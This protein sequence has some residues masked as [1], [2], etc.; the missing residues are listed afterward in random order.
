MLSSAKN[1]KHNGSLKK[2]AVGP[3]PQAVKLSRQ[4][5]HYFATSLLN[6]NPNSIFH[7]EE[8]VK[9]DINSCFENGNRSDEF[10]QEMI[11]EKYDID[12]KDYAKASETA[13]LDTIEYFVN[14][15]VPMLTA[16]MNESNSNLQNPKDSKNPS[17]D[18]K[19]LFTNL[20]EFHKE[21]TTE[22]KILNNLYP[23][24]KKLVI[25]TD[26]VEK[27]AV[28]PK[29][30]RK[31]PTTPSTDVSVSNFDPDKKP[32]PYDDCGKM[33]TT[34]GALSYH[35]R[36]KH[37]RSDTS[38]KNRPS[39]I[40]PKR[41]FPSRNQIN[42][43]KPSSSFCLTPQPSKPSLIEFPQT[44]NFNQTKN[45]VKDPQTPILNT[46]A[47]MQGSQEILNQSA[48]VIGKNTVESDSESYK[49]STIGSTTAAT[50]KVSGVE[51]NVEDDII[52]KKAFCSESNK[53]FG[54]IG[55]GHDNNYNGY[56]SGIIHGGGEE[57]YAGYVDEDEIQLNQ[58][59]QFFNRDTDGQIKRDSIFIGLEEF[60]EGTTVGFPPVD[61]SDNASFIMLDNN[62]PDF[63]KLFC[64]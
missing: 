39:P 53:F 6:P 22:I 24:K 32:C 27:V 14:G 42:K 8:L 63:G 29:R 4:D 12:P 60:D 45:T 21:S 57:M 23:T 51:N 1:S 47:P 59:F 15:F 18:L 13:F 31:H 50:I 54:L 7:L 37:R 30:S 36:T 55:I 2:D 62:H 11:Q 56:R 26:I 52:I 20:M 44:A 25:D 5:F 10:R 46:E 58:M 49:R 43:I 33:Y 35:I 48:V 38:E 64:G 61:A 16:S 9:E 34:N 41:E 17:T 40:L 19:K 28:Q 3:N